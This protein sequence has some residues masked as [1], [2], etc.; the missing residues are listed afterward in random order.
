MIRFKDLEYVLKTPL[1]GPHNVVD[2]DLST[3][4]YI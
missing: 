1:I 3:G 2:E 4:H